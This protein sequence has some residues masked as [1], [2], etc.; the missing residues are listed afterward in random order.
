M[1]EL[2]RK[3][4]IISFYKKYPL[5]DFNYYIKLNKVKKEKTK[6]DYL[7][8]YDKLKNK[9]NI[10]TNLDDF[11]EIYPAF[12]IYF[13]KNTY[14]DLS[15]LYDIELLEHWINIGKSKNRYINN[16]SYFK[17]NSIDKL[18]IKIFYPEMSNY[19]DSEIT[20][21]IISKNLIY[22]EETFIQ[23]YPNFNILD[24][25]KINI[26][27]NNYSN[28]DLMAHWHNIGKHNNKFCSIKDLLDYHKD[29]DIDIYKKFNNTNNIYTCDDDIIIEWYNYGRFKDD[30]IWSIDTFKNKYYGFDFNEFK[31]IYPEFTNMKNKDIVDFYIK[32]YSDYRNTHFFNYLRCDGNNLDLYVFEEFINFQHMLTDKNY[33]ILLKKLARENKINTLV[34][35]IADFKIKYP[36][37]NL[38]CYKKFNKN[39]IFNS[40]NEYIYNWYIKDKNNKNILCSM[41]MFYELYPDFKLKIYN[42]FNENKDVYYFYEYKYKYNLIHSIDTFKNNYPDFNYIFYKNYNKLDNLNEEEIIFH[43]LTSNNNF[44]S[45]IKNI[46][47]NINIKIYRN[48]NIDIKHLSDR[49]LLNN[50]L[51]NYNKEERV[52]SIK[53]FYNKYPQYEFN[54]K[55]K[56]Y[57]YEK[58]I[59]DRFVEEE[60]KII[61]LMTE[62]ISKYN[63]NNNN[64]IGRQYVNSVYDVLLDMEE[65][66]SKKKKLM[67]GISLII[68]AK[69]EELNVKFCIESV[70]DLVEEIIFV[71]NGST[72]NTYFEV[73]K[74]AKK[75]KNIKLYKYDISVSRAGVAHKEALANKNPNTLGLFY[76]WCLSKS[77]TYN[78]F[79]WDADF[80]CIRN[81]FIDLVNKYNVKKRDDKFS[82]WF[83]GLTLFENKNN[84]YVN[85]NSYYDEF[86]IYSYKNG[87]KWSDGEIC[88]YVEPYINSIDRKYKY[89]YKYPLFYE[90]KRTSIDEFESRSSMIDRRDINDFNILTGL[91]ED[92]LTNIIPISEKIIFNTKRILLVCS[93][94][95]IGGANSFI[96]NM[97]N[98]I[99]KLGY[100]VKIL[101]LNNVSIGADKYTDIIDNDI[102][103]NDTQVDRKMEED[104]DIILF[105]STL[106]IDSKKL[107]KLNQTKRIIFVTHSD[108]GYSN[109]FIMNYSTYFDKIITVNNYTINKLS[110][111]LN[112]N[113]NSFIRLINYFEFN[114]FKKVDEYKNNNDMNNRKIHNKF[115]MVSRF[116]EDK[117]V[118]M[119]LYS[120]QS[121]FAKHPDYKCVLVGCG[122]S[123]DY[124]N[125]LKFL[126]KKFR[127]DKNVI[128]EG[129]QKDV[130]KYY[131][132]SDFSVLLSVSEG[133]PYAILESFLYKCPVLTTNVGG[134]NELIE[135]E[136]SGMLINYD[137]IRELESKKIYIHNYDEHLT[138][139]G[140]IQNEL[141]NKCYEKKIAF[142][143]AVYIPEHLSLL[144]NNCNKCDDCNY[145][146]KQKNI[147]DTN[148]NKISNGI[149]KMIENNYNNVNNDYAN[150]AYNFFIEEF[151][152]NNYVKTILE[153]IE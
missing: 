134:N 101:P 77:T 43:Y 74:Y 111:M 55:N 27:L 78:V 150:E 112:I 95:S 32:K 22:N 10:I 121:V 94:L 106:N 117:N 118:P 82:I 84:Y 52:Y 146:M 125:Y 144:C 3:F 23:K 46:E 38:E 120:L 73:E 47:K 31:F 127:I 76:N 13:Y 34:L 50:F 6:I 36:Y 5:F 62:G 28:I 87:F 141:I 102:I 51:N 39:I 88:E 83:T 147:W 137:N 35:S 72:D 42:F 79:K 133:T 140:Y 69:N 132:N 24:Y 7:N 136:K 93:S 1:N 148:A 37:F 57:M 54:E 128:F 44:Q 151:S 99:K 97:Y 116:S 135:N 114:D 59:Y 145:H 11:Y 2:S 56:Y 40:D 18:F 92:K 15:E 29:F 25:K 48:L 90:M 119:L 70:V 138:T 71:D 4:D 115:C 67:P 85:Y 139:I 17:N 20:Y 96:L 21:T 100:Q 129:Y 12:D 131:E 61:Y 30:K 142:N 81:N 109:Y 86:R 124:D 126:A 41:E 91:K 45:T 130:K 143:N 16:N 108:V 14:P 113:K 103:K 153:L 33:K 122:D 80:L 19:S 104:F 66:K 60:D 149:M 110:N 152:Q 89:I 105:N 123:V 49:D 8:S 65:E 68:R 98:V 64:L 26:E 58:D 107:M 75:Y 63:L 53:S 9:N